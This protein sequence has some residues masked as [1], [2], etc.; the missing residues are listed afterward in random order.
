MD[1]K[2]P[3]MLTF[4]GKQY[5]IRHMVKLHNDS[6]YCRMDST[7]SFGG[8]FDFYNFITSKLDDLDENAKYLF[9]SSTYF[10]MEKD[11]EIV[12]SF[13]FS[14]DKAQIIDALIK[15][16][17]ELQVKFTENEIITQNAKEYADNIHQV[18]VD[19][20]NENIEADALTENTML[21]LRILGL[22]KQISE[23]I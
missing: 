3:R 2:L 19:T 5:K 1:P 4:N 13:S 9:G 6:W 10:C 12:T 20:A 22:E 11:G 8:I 18:I 14:I 21:K 23:R 16:H 17:E 7:V 15:Q